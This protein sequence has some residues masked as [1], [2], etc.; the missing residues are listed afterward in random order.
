MPQFTTSDLEKLSSI[1]PELVSIL[2]QG[3]RIVPFMVIEGFRGRVAQEKAFVEGKTKLHWPEGKHNQMPSVAVDIGPVYFE[4]NK[5]A[6]DWSDYIAFGRIMGIIQAIAFDR[7]TKLRFGL[8]WDGDFR[9]AGRDPGETF[10]DAPH[11]EIVR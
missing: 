6:I 3:I 5:R 10:L 8:D 4:A 7:G 2:H 9:S 11:V 1:D